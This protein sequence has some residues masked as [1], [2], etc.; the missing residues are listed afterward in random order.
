MKIATDHI[1]VVCNILK[2]N[3]LLNTL[4]PRQNDHRFADDTFKRIFLNENVRISIK[5]SLK[6]VPKGPINNTSDAP[7][8]NTGFT[9]YAKKASIATTREQSVIVTT[10]LLATGSWIDDVT[11]GQHFESFGAVTGCVDLRQ[12]SHMNH[13]NDWCTKYTGSEILG[14]Y[15]S[16]SARD[17]GFR[18]DSEYFS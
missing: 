7:C 5:I 10:Q 2:H 14:R 9:K 11:I 16:V 12:L 6:F 3:V 8:W 18:G 15:C 4:R 17:L 1:V 13:I